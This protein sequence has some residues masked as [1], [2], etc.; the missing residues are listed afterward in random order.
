MRSEGGRLTPWRG[1]R[2]GK[3]EP[4]GQGRTDDADA[5]LCV[6]SFEPGAVARRGDVLDLVERTV[7]AARGRQQVEH[8]ARGLLGVRVGEAV[9]DAG[10]RGPEVAGTQLDEVVTELER[11]DTFENVERVFLRGVHVSGRAGAI[12]DVGNEEVEA[13][14]V[15]AAVRLEGPARRVAHRVPVDGP[16][17]RFDARRRPSAPVRVAV[18]ALE[19]HA[20]GTGAVSP[21]AAVPTDDAANAVR[22][23]GGV[24]SGR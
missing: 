6:E 7:E 18:N 2:L 15:V 21:R 23:P 10:R 24:S 1:W 11:E 5:E 20:V 9:W 4:L 14:F 8:P 22:Q 17:F 3:R 16:P 12:R 13:S 19:R